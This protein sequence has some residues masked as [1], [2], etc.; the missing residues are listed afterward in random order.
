MWGKILIPMYRLWLHS[1]YGLYGPRCPLSPKRSINLIS[2]SLEHSMSESVTTK[3]L[4]KAWKNLFSFTLTNLFMNL[5]Y[6]QS[7]NRGIH[8]QN[9]RISEILWNRCIH[10]VST[11][12]ESVILHDGIQRSQ[13]ATFGSMSPLFW[14]QLINQSL[15]PLNH[16]QLRIFKIFDT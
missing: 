14:L 10:N 8:W 2:L 13:S 6:Q 16:N 3:L 4:T 12:S 9:D 5:P 1:L 15:N 11:N 7:K